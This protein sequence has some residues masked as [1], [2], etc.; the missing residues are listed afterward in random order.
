MPRSLK[1]LAD[2]HLGLRHGDS[3]Q[4]VDFVV[5][6]ILMTP[7]SLRLKRTNL[8]SQGFLKALNIVPLM[9]DSG[10]AIRRSPITVN[11]NRMERV[12]LGDFEDRASRVAWFR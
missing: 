8:R 4:S 2:V 5:N 6:G 11:T 9:S 1:L 12:I 10:R 3:L 7:K